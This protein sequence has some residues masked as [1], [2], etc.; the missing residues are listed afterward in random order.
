MFILYSHTMALSF[1]LMFEQRVYKSVV[2]VVVIIIIMKM[3][4][5]M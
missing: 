5:K 1:V 3:I 2:E 4:S